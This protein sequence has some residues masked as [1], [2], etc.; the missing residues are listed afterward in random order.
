MSSLFVP[1]HVAVMGADGFWARRREDM[2][3]EGLQRND[4]LPAYVDPHQVPVSPTSTI[5]GSG[6]GSERFVTRLD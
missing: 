3:G 2:S 1:F 4:T 6:F 5:H